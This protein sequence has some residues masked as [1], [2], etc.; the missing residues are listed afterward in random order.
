M[1][2]KLSIARTLLHHPRLIFLDEPTAGLDP[3]MAAA[4]RDDLAA[5]VRQ[6]GVTV[7]LTTHNL[8]EAEKLCSLIAVIRQGKLLAIGRPDEL[9]SQGGARRVEIVGRGFSDDLVAML[10]R[11]PEIAVVNRQT[12]RL[13][14]ELREET[15]IAPLTS[16]LVRAGA[17][18]EEIH[19][20]KAS[21]EEVFLTL[22]QEAQ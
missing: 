6:E 15:D 18:V 22:M 19:K 14:L 20:G 7:F 8:T 2:Q 16:L 5:L 11:R 1:R 12:N 4:L 9:R 3:V 13:L 17:E 10:Q 21:L